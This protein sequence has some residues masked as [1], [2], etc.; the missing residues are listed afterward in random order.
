MGQIVNTFTD[1]A[2]GTLD[3]VGVADAIA[4]KKVSLAEV[5]EAAIARV[6]QANESLHA[7]V[8]DTYDDARRPYRLAKEGALYGVPALIKDNDHLR[9]YPTQHGTGAFKSKVA[10]ENGIFVR[11]LFSTGVN[12]L[13]KTTMPEFGL[14]CSA[15]NAR[16]GITR[17]PWNTDHMPGGSSSGSAAMVASGAVPLATANDGAGSIR[18]PAACCGLVGLKPSRGR[19]VAMDGTERLLINIVHEGVVTRSVRDTAAFY[20]AAERFYR[21]PALPPLGHVEG[22]SKSRLRIAWLENPAPGQPGH[23]DED[24]YRVQ[25]ETAYLLESLGHQLERIR[26]PV[27]IEQMTWHFLNYYGMLAY[28]VSHWGEFV[29]G[30]RVDKSLVETFT[31]G[32]ARR[33]RR[34]ILEFTKSLSILR[35]AARDSEALFEGRF[36]LLMAP[37]GAYVTPKIGY[38]S[39]DLSF[40]EICHRAASYAPYTGLH[41]VTGSPSISLPLGM[42]SNGMP[43]G[44]QFTAG[45]GQDKRVLE[46]AYELEIA[47]PWKLLHEVGA[48]PS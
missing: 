47:K 34:N 37:V 40:D 8:F 39:P 4:T 35:Q 9:G 22:P 3:A 43:I 21:N 46:L 42:D 27:D 18:I 5:T 1:D 10:Q 28:L 33:F 32:L 23:I 11:Q 38:F 17:N 24:T 13:G 6:K 29:F 48:C 41:N 44:V 2:L 36:D 25:E 14:L 12:C 26:I 7:L 19:L 16:W 20:A 31:M 45:L 15:E 30:V